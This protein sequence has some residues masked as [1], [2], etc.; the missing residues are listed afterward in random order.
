MGSCL[1]SEKPDTN[2]KI[3]SKI[4]MPIECSCNSSCC[5]PK[6][7]HHHKHHIDGGVPSSISP[8]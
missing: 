4:D 8:S 3:K 2:I 7:K 6:K 5:M 1:S